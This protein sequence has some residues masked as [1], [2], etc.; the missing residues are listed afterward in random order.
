MAEWQEYAK[1][2]G[3][4]IDDDALVQGIIRVLKRKPAVLNEVLN[5]FLTDQE[6]YQYN[7]QIGTGFTVKFGSVVQITRLNENVELSKKQ[8]LEILAVVDALYSEIYPLGTIVELDK[9][10]VMDESKDQFS[11]L[12][13]FYVS[14]IGQRIIADD[15]Y[16]DYVATLYPNGARGDEPVPLNNHLIKRVVGRGPETPL[17]KNYAEYLRKEI[18]DGGKVPISYAMW[19]GGIDD[20]D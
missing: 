18:V 1:N 10:L 9:D 14:I 11:D 16:L 5:A 20:A 8:F 6:K 2:C 12:D 4:E 7:P 19:I 3:F 17:T 13:Y 15:N